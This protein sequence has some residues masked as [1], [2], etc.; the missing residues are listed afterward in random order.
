MIVLSW[1]NRTAG[2][3]RIAPVEN[4]AVHSARSINDATIWP[5]WSSTA[6]SQRNGKGGWPSRTRI[7]NPNDRLLITGG[8][9]H[10]LRWS[11][12]FD[13]VKMAARR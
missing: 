7:E 5:L 2:T 10:E 6:D 11:D 9:L 1:R 3:N 4:V 13:P 12:R 8:L